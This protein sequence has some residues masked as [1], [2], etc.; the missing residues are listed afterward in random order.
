[1]NTESLLT[2]FNQLSE[3]PDAL[4]HL[5]RFI[6]DLAV[7]GRLAEQVAS[8]EP[9][10]ELLS[11]I[12]SHMS[13]QGTRR[14]KYTSVSPAGAPYQLPQGWEW[15]RVRHISADRGQTRPTESFTYIDVGSID[16]EAGRIADAVVLTANKAPSRARKIVKRGDVLYSCVRPYL[17]NIAVVEQSFEPTPI[18]STA[19]AV[20]DAFGLVSPGYLWTVLRSPFMV[21]QVELKMRGQAYPAINDSDFAQLP[22]PLPPLAE[23]Q[24]IVRN[25]TS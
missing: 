9:A 23:Q 6:L 18:A 20:L 17:L 5:R 22:F 10:S 7:R 3:A 19:F 24:R 14:R 8:D 16:N 21:E 2:E 4:Q 11:R 15:V 12:E 25:V 1:V 13:D